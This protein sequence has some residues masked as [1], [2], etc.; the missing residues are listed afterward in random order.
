M[1]N[2]CKKSHFNEKIISDTI[3]EVITWSRN[4]EPN[5]TTVLK[6]VKKEPNEKNIWITNLKNLM[7][8]TTREKEW[9]PKTCITYKRPRTIQGWLT[10]YKKLSKEKEQ[11]KQQ[12]KG[13]Y[14]CGKCSLCGGIKRFKNMVKETDK[15]KTPDGKTIL[16]KN[17]LNC[18]NYGI[19]RANCNYCKHKYIGQTKTSFT[20]RWNQ[21]RAKWKE[22]INKRDI[23]EGNW[24]KDE[25]ALYKHFEKSHKDKLDNK[26]NMDEAY[27]LVFLEEPKYFKLDIEESNWISKTKAEINITR[28]FLPKIM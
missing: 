2:K 17:R 19:Y 3:N 12:Q 13:S 15:T 27:H 6:K 21:H 20:K 22:L 25:Q 28:T 5:E 18:K 10:N 4:L 14:R 16:L 11:K 1:E 24:N 9:S 7:K 23:T 26:I 8:L